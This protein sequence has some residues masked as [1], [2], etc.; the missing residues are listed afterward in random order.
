MRLQ[1]TLAQDLFDRKEFNRMDRIKRIGK[2]IKSSRHE[3]LLFYPV[4]AV[5]PV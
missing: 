1:G 5:H 4:Y 3:A 2:A